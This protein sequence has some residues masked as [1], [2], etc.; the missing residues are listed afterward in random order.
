M[1]K[2]I[3]II[4]IKVKCDKASWWRICY[5]RGLHCLFCKV[6]YI[7][8]IPG[9]LDWTTLTIQCLIKICK[10]WTIYIVVLFLGS[11]GICS[12]R[13]VIAVRMCMLSKNT[14]KNYVKVRVFFSNKQTFFNRFLLMEK[15]DCWIIWSFPENC[16]Q[17]FSC[18]LVKTSFCFALPTGSKK[19]YF[20]INKYHIS[21][22]KAITI[23]F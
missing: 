5:Q 1:S 13:F 9:L 19:K 17:L 4:Q 14:P 10:A 18:I 16:S 6:C 3:Y 22:S 23:C 15:R 12:L 2:N 21:V 20:V 8:N 11:I 7:F